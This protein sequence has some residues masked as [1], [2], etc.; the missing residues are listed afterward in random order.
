[1]FTRRRLIIA[2]TVSMLVLSVLGIF[3]LAV[4]PMMVHERMLRVLES[5][6]FNTAYIP[7][8]RKRFGAIL[9]ENVSFD[10]DAFSTARY[11][12]VTYNPL[13]FP[14]TGQLKDLDVFDLNLTGDWGSG[15]WQ[16]LTFAGWKPPDLSQI[17]FAR[18]RH[19]GISKS[20]VSLLTQSIGGISVFIDGEGSSKNGKTEFRSNVSTEQKSLVLN[21]NTTTIIE[22]PRW[23]TD[24]EITDGKL[25]D[26]ELSRGKARVSRLN[27]WMNISDP[28]NEPL[29][30]KA[31]LRSGGFSLYE[32]PWQDGAATLDY[33]NGSTRLFI[34]GRSVGVAGL[35]LELNMFIGQ[36]VNPALG[37]TVHADSAT[38]FFDYLSSNKKFDSF[39]NDL[40]PYKDDTKMSVD[41]LMEPERDG[42]YLRYAIKSSS[43]RLLKSGRLLLWN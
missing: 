26:P 42:L 2:A 24:F 10:P 34:E 1:M 43:D 31:R 17:P 35:K 30:L 12:K 41:F 40:K 11:I 20:R 8:P 23:S 5:A 32:I 37:G 15:S 16:S 39:L 25:E 27:G 3:T 13:V 21:G 28:R 4:V 38:A 22:G 36:G 19:V 18:F 7:E 14:F 6:G 33:T 29:S 9:Y